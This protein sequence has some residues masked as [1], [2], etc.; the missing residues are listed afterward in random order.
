MVC[1]CSC[2]GGVGE[3]SFSSFGTTK[4]TYLLMTSFN[5]LLLQVYLQL[6][7]KSLFI[8][9]TVNAVHFIIA[10]NQSLSNILM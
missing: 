6:F 1:N 4:A 3:L 2:I 10:K 9:L 8:A 7:I 5:I